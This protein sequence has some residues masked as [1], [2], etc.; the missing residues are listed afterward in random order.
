MQ[1][2][3]SDRQFLWQF[4]QL[5]LPAEQFNH[6]GHLKIAWL[7][8]SMSTTEQACD[9][10]CCGIR[11]YAASLGAATKFHFTI[12]QALVLIM[13][14]RITKTEQTGGDWQ[15]FVT[16]NQD[17]VDNA[18]NVLYQYYSPDLLHSELAKN[19]WCEPDLQAL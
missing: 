3:Q 7:Y 8:L 18:L 5:T 1:M 10:A 6:L 2:T 4:E 19:A 12:T 14:L 15:A 9:K 13:A 11:N 17:L 16:N